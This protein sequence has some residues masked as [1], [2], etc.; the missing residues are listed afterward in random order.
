M[1]QIVA[2]NTNAAT[3]SCP[4]AAS[5][6]VTAPL[7]QRECFSEFLPTT[8]YIGFFGGR[9]VTFR[10]TARAGRPS[11]GGIGSAETKVAGGPL[12][13]PFAV[14]GPSVGQTVMGNAPQLVT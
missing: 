10:F 12:R 6:T 7:A 1:G 2:G 5:T 13:G 9:P 3:G 11:G 14:T 4:A 8:D